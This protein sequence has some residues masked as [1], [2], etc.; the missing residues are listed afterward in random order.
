M[1]DLGNASTNLIGYSIRGESKGGPGCR[2]RFLTTGVLLRRM[3]SDPDLEGISH[4]FVDEVSRSSR[5][6]SSL[7]IVC[8]RRSTNVV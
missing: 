4:V 8:S 1:E 2:L 5:A 3:I 7:I 6:S